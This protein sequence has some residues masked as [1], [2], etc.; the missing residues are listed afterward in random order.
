LRRTIDISIEG[1]IFRLN[2]ENLLRE[3]DFLVV[4]ELIFYLKKIKQKNIEHRQIHGY[5]SHVSI[6][7]LTFEI[8]LSTMFQYLFGHYQIDSIAKN[9]MDKI[10]RH[11]KSN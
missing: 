7:K 6:S 5:T 8:D 3:N 2:H 11:L 9:A 10:L 1:S 4:D